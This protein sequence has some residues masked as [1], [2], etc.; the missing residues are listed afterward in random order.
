[1]NTTR[2]VATL[3]AALALQAAALAQT[4]APAPKPAAPAV[5]EANASTAGPSKASPAGTPGPSAQAPAATPGQAQGTPGAA[6][7]GVQ[8][9][10]Q[11]EAPKGARPPSGKPPVVVGP[12]GRTHAASVPQA[13]TKVA[14]PGS[15]SAVNFAKPATRS[16]RVGVANSGAPNADAS[17]N[18]TTAVASIP[19][20][21]RI[22]I[23]SGMPSTDSQAV[24]TWTRNGTTLSADASTPSGAGTAAGSVGNAISAGL[25]A[26]S[27]VTNSNASAKG[28]IPAGIVNDML[29]RIGGMAS[30]M[31]NK[32]STASAAE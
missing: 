12:D 18:S 25:L 10:V 26:S 23:A 14:M 8:G 32:T 11:G 4:A 30:Q 16:I 29:V 7:S 9:G 13:S 15:R 20:T 28:T 1:M 2:T 19:L 3:F 5:T 22:A 31:S 6:A 17:T 21:S 27:S 24:H